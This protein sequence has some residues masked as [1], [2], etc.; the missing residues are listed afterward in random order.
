MFRSLQKLSNVDLGVESA[1]V[2]TFEVRAASGTYPS[3]GDR[4]EMG[5]PVP[6]SGAGHPR[7]DGR[8]RG[9]KPS[10]AGLPVEQ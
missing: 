1:G 5:A 4:V 6:R 3:G 10:P 8:R 2:L 9:P 7:R